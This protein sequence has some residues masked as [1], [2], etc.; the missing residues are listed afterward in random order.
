MSNHQCKETHC[1]CGENNSSYDWVWDDKFQ[2]N[3]LKLDEKSLEVNFHPI[4]SNGTAAVRGN[5][6]L[7]K[8]RHHY[9]EVEMLTQI[10]G[11]DVMVGVGTK[12]TNLLRATNSFE[13]LLGMDGESWGYSYRGNIQHGGQMKAYQGSFNK[14]NLVGVHLDTWKGVLQ[15]F[16]NRKPL[17]IAFTGLR[18][19][20]LYPM[21][22]STAAKSK[23]RITYCSSIPA[24][25]Q[26]ECLAVLRPSHKAYLNTAFPGLKYL[27][28]SIF[29][30]ILQN[31]DDDDDDEE[32][33]EDD[34][35]SRENLHLEDFDVTMKQCRKR[36]KRKLIV[37]HT[38]EIS[39]R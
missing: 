39:S 15:F 21:V 19:F 3:K 33:D 13:S 9:W 30:D 18:G 2:T 12:K 31:D 29:A 28:K 5:K 27:S 17:G 35:F 37:R 38:F 16:L 32:N 7:S 10:Y 8:N 14:G 23:M 26:T 11:T 6:I 1:D 24:S 25:L 34:E 4:F 20:K 22:C 36:K